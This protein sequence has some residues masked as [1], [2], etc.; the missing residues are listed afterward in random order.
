MKAKLLSRIKG[1]HGSHRTRAL[2]ARSTFGTLLLLV[3]IGGALVGWLLYQR[4][5]ASRTSTPSPPA[6]SAVHEVPKAEPPPSEREQAEA[7]P[8]RATR[9]VPVPASADSPAP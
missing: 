1:R 7:L 5:R 4:Q 6:T 3:A 2:C 8:R 9:A